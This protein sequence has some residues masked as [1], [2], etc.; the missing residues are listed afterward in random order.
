MN[1]CSLRIFITLDLNYESPRPSIDLQ[2]LLNDGLV[3]NF[4]TDYKI[5]N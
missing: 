2:L 5:L 1:T 3:C 4:L